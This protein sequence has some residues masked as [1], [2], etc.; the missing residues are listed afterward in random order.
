MPT[1]AQKALIA[2]IRA[3]PAQIAALVGGLSEQQ[4]LAHPEGEWTIAQN[5]HHLADSHMNAYLRVHFALAEDHPTI[6]PYLQNMWAELPDATS[7]DVTDSLAL[8]TALH[9]RWVYLFEC[10]AD[11]QFERV[12]YHPEQKADISV[13][14]IL[15][16]YANH[17]EAHIRQI[18][19]ALAT[20]AH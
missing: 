20:L 17:G 9:A 15:E 2:K 4:L 14:V 18:T 6:K 19:E 3:L 11:D 7:A 5:V 16:Y 13:Q 8:L 1:D 10:L 12:V